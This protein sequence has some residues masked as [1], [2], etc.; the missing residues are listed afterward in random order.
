MTQTV[1]A[2]QYLNAAKILMHVDVPET[3]NDV[4]V[5]TAQDTK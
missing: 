3:T 5:S 2:S 4:C 1:C